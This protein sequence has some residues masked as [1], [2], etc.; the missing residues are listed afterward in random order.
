MSGTLWE[1]VRDQRRAYATGTIFVAVGIVAALAYPQVIRLIID[2]GIVGGRVERINALG[3]LMLALLLVEAVATFMRNGLFNLAAE[4][5]AAQL[6]QR[7]FEHLLQQDIAFFDS[8]TTGELTSRLAT[9]IPALQR[10]FGDNLAD[11]MRNVL[12]GVGGSALLFYT[13]PLLSIVVLLSVPPIVAA[14]SMLGRRVKRLSAAMQHT[15]AQAGTIAEEGLAGI[16][17][18]RAFA[19]EPAEAARYRGTLQAA[20]T[21]AKR[22]IVATSATSSIAFL[23]GEGAAVLAIWAGGRLILKGQLTSGALI[24]FILYAFLVARGFRNASDFWNETVR[25]VGATEWIFALLARP[26]A[27]RHERGERRSRLIG[28]V[29]F[30]RVRFAYPTRPETDAVAEVNLRIEP[31]EVVAVVG[32]S[33]SG[34]STLLN[35]LL[36][37]YEPSE[38]RILVDS[39]DIRDV[40][41]S[42]L[43][44]EIGVVLQE[45]VLFSR[46]VAENIRF[47]RPDAT[48][49]E[50]ATAADLAQ[51]REFISRAADEFETAIGDRGVRLSG[52]QRQRIAIAR[53]MIKR[54]AIL[55]LDEATSALDAGNESLVHQALRA[56]DYRPT[57]IIVAHRLST[58]VNVDRVIV[59]EAGRC[60]AT[61]RHDDLLRTCDFYRQLVDTQLVGV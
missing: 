37:F 18:L 12:W 9:A 39:I 49:A 43:R 48:D 38:G 33:G 47:G 29:S 10:A 34:K 56:L 55:L 40:D 50:V 5:M 36:R 52:G 42:W 24:S 11:A 60:V 31:G 3:L 19:R 57:T 1:L 2:E 23:T 16:R 14:S 46:S 17:T 4:R 41:P 45:P 27:R 53:A 8:H 61:G 20:L 26:P 25:S 7:T 32:P 13:S 28:R 59:L 21:I 22:K 6:Q 51:A 15:Y 44:R 35:L 58:V 30:E 54:P